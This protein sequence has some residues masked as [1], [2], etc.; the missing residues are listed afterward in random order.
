MKTVLL[1]TA[2]FVVM[3]IPQA[4][5]AAPIDTSSLVQRTC[6]TA[7]KGSPT[8]A[9]SRLANFI[10]ADVGIAPMD[11]PS[12][13]DPD[14]G[15]RMVAAIV[16][17]H[18]AEA[19]TDQQWQIKYV[20]QQLEFELGRGSAIPFQAEGVRAANPGTIPGW[21]FQS[22]DNDTLTCFVKEAAG[23]DA[24]A[25]P[26]GS[27]TRLMLRQMADDLAL[28]SLK[29]AGSA[30]FGYTR[31]RSRLS[32]G[33][34]KTDSTWTIDATLGLRINPAEAAQ[35]Y[36]LYA[37][38]K[39]KRARTRPVPQLPVGQSESD[40][41]IDV[42]EVGAG[43]GFLLGSNQL[44]ANVSVVND[45]ADNSNRLKASAQFIPAFFNVNLGFCRVGEATDPF[46]IGPWKFA[47]RCSVTFLAEAN[48]VFHAGR[49]T[50][51]KNDEFLLA[52]GKVGWELFP[53]GKD[54]PAAS[55]FYRREWRVAGTSPSIDRL[56]A[57]LGYR[58]F[59]S[60][61]FAVDLGLTYAK[62]RDPKSF[63]PEDKL[64]VSFGL[65]F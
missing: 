48:H 57:F 46:H 10:L 53:N 44:V 42:L 62:G 13:G 9:R 50:F 18:D 45:L 35:P 22:A 2:T 49:G 11:L 4:A 36:Y 17:A 31:E 19:P 51:T 14:L 39:R 27:V 52:G 37:S 55:L 41:D 30:K 28:D 16:K 38:Y 40:S 6:A 26:P 61:R 32:D 64:E 29:K 33:T 21:L 3:M 25:T 23:A 58:V 1:G 20:V 54:G 56:D 15:A 47:A 60:Q 5:R 24:H 63:K 12:G 8:V 65:L 7:T 43:G 59:V 34:R